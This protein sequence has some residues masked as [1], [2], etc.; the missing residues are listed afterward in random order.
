MTA[1][2]GKS[3]SGASNTESGFTLLEVM[4]SMVIMTVG[5]V[6]LLA[7]MGIA[8]ASTAT[9]EQNAISKRLADEALES[10]LTARETDEVQW[11]N[12]ANGNCVVGTGCTTGIFLTGTQN[13][14]L[15]GVDGIVGTSDD[16]AAGPQVLDLPGPSGVVQSPDG[17]PCALPDNCL[18]LTNYQRTIV[19][20]PVNGTLDQVTITVSYVNAQL[21][22]ANNYVLS[23]LVSEYR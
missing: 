8:M 19:I 15:P 2:T 16:A 6:S 21:K 9:S 3:R 18:Q 22:V 12:I 11:S 20:T 5:L 13:I 14:D 4:F 10:I 23:T 7:V 1:K 17:G